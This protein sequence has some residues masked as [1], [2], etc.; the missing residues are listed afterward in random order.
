MYLLCFL[1]HSSPKILSI[2]FNH[3]VSYSKRPEKAF[4]M[5][6]RTRLLLTGTDDDGYYISIQKCAVK[7]SL[8]SK[9]RG[10]LDLFFI[11]FTLNHLTFTDLSA[12]LTGLLIKGCSKQFFML[13]VSDIK[14][15]FYCRQNW[16]FSFWIP[17]TAV[18]LISKPF[19]TLVN[20]AIN[21][22]ILE[23]KPE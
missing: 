7:I 12:T 23:T 6:A 17:K 19:N 10:F 9:A 4:K 14:Q 2:S 21:A 22:L 11:V 1:F 16:H 13:R 20:F 18:H 3:L 5:W 15:H 8:I